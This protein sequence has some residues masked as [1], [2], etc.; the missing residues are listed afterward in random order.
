M[1]GD[2]KEDWQ[3]VSDRSVIQY[4]QIA[5]RT[6]V[7]EIRSNVMICLESSINCDVLC[8]GGSCNMLRFVWSCNVLHGIVFCNV[9]RCIESCDV[10]L[11]ARR[12]CYVLTTYSSR[13]RQG[14]AKRRQTNRLGSRLP[15]RFSRDA[16]HLDR[17]VDR[18]ALDGALLLF[19]RLPRAIRPRDIFDHMG[20]SQLVVL[21]RGGALGGGVRS[22]D[23]VLFRSHERRRSRGSSRRRRIRMELIRQR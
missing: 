4:M 17:V 3:D 14:D 10:S 13:R 9:L 12:K 22:G 2:F 6:S 5:L 7:N 16:N 20:R 1:Y 23:V 21:G 18:A 11:A 8:C 19:E 15:T